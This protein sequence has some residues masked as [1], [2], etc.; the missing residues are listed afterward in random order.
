MIIPIHTPEFP[1]EVHVYPSTDYEKG[2][3]TITVKDEKGELIHQTTCR[4]HTQACDDNPAV[5]FIENIARDVWN[6]KTSSKR[7]ECGCERCDNFKEPDKL[8]PQRRVGFLRKCINLV[9]QFF[10][11]GS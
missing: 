10:K 6:Q 5:K 3:I 2:L 7:I 9:S 8:S 1:K 11:S 4:L